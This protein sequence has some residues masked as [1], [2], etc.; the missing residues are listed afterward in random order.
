MHEGILRMK[1]RLLA[2]LI[3]GVFVPVMGAVCS[4]AAISLG[5]VDSF[6]VKA[7]PGPRG[8][9]REDI[10]R[11]VV[12]EMSADEINRLTA[13]RPDRLPLGPVPRP[14][15]VP[16]SP[17]A[18][19]WTNIGPMPVE[20]E[21]W[22]GYADASGRISAVLLDPSHPG[23]MYIAGAQ[24]GVWKSYDGGANW[25]P[26]TDHLSS[27]SSG[28]LAYVPYA[29]DILYYGTGELHY[30]STC[31]YGDGL[32]KS[33]DGGD[34]WIKIAEKATVGSYI[35]RIIVKPTDHK[36]VH[37]AGDLGYLR[38]TDDAASWNVVLGID[39]CNDL[40]LS[41][42]APAVVFAAIRANG[43][44][45]S[46]DD[47]ASWSQCTGGLPASGFGRINIAISQSDASVLYASFVS[48]STGGL[49]GMYRTGD[50]GSTWV[51]LVNTP[52]YLHGQGW[53]DNCVIVDQG[54][55]LV[56][57]AGGVFPFS[58]GQYG[59]IKTV[60]GG[61]S[62]TD[63]TIGAVSGQIHPDQ[64]SLAIGADGALWVGC[65]GGLWKTTDRGDTWINLNHNLG[66]TQFYTVGLHPTDPDFLLGGTQDQGSVRFD[67][68]LGWP[69]VIGG[70]GGPCAVE[71]DSPN[72]YY[73]TYVLMDPIF[74]W[75]NGVYVGDATGPWGGTGE[76]ASWC[77]G[78]L[79][80]DRSRANT[81]LAGTYRIWRTN[82]SGG[83]WTPISGDL[84]GGSGHL[85]SIAVA[86]GASDTIYAGSS[87]G[88]VHVTTD[89][90]S[91]S[92]RNSGLPS[93]P[94]P[95]IV[96]N[97]SD[98]RE[99]Y[100]CIYQSTG[101]R[102]YH[103]TD[104]G[105][106]WTD[107]TGDLPGGLRGMSLAVDFDTAPPRIFLGTDYG[108]YSS[109]DGGVTWIEDSTGLPSMEIYDLGLDAVNGLLV[110]ATHGR[111]MYRAPLTGTPACMK[112]G[113]PA[114]YVDF[115]GETRDVIAGE[116]VCWEIAPANFGFVSGLCPD[117]DTFCVWAEDTEGWTITGDPPLEACT[118]LDAGYVWYQD[119]CIAVPCETAVSE[120]D[121]LR[122]HM[123]YCDGSGVCRHD[124]T[125]CED[126]NWW[127]GTPYFS[128]DTVVLHV[129]PSP[130]A[131]F[132]VQDSLS[133]VEMGQSAGY[134]LFTICNGNACSPP[135]AYEY[136]IYNTGYFAEGF[137]QCGTTPPITGGECEN[138]Y[139]IVDAGTAEAC[140]FDTLLIVAWDA[141]T[142]TAYDTCVQVVHAVT[143][144]PVPV[145]EAPFV[146]VLVSVLIL[147]TA[148][149][150]WNRIKERR[151][152]KWR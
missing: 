108:V 33:Y 152:M 11:P 117:A 25:T 89:A 38:S 128:A 111:G 37:L 135:A 139:G 62:W 79:V 137:P 23:W 151:V 93:S 36:I 67:G 4:L 70:D 127:A 16:M 136:C 140:D 27:L 6:A 80:V 141:A 126:P 26:L 21:Y 142:G 71:W 7:D 35:T 30:A 73:T 57:F 42:A 32:F 54:D 132:I 63:I 148:L 98:W 65:D 131:L 72:I 18:L 85:R 8:A 55:P 10:P 13:E 144:M 84:T 143:P 94:V 41:G 58:E 48:S 22:S 60:D 76:R 114:F 113:D 92:L 82:D 99:A 15:A 88:L 20:N 130:P 9:A 49:L 122:I 53:Y 125:D 123:T 90:A 116:T 149:I 96:L 81:L 124:C 145:F 46:T 150:L 112:E 14:W 133:Y 97:P 43:I 101:G 45:K 2:G 64:H 75:D 83:S 134:L 17:S 146:L 91:W 119:V 51:H 77:N 40:A 147:A 86:S 56:C 104:A 69:Q 103:T 24:G 115:G 34:S 47:G 106:I 120:H 78:P 28:D 87:N 12:F 68:D 19:Y 121:T 109:V 5:P 102:V 66:L 59:M 39:H 105:V 1:D 129:V 31:C 29:P 110:A 50:A 3:Y 107:I 118:I 138:V 74:K 52:N 95:D 61:D 100:L 44:Y